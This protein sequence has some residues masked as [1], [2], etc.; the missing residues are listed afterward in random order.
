MIRR[1][2]LIDIL[3]FCSI[4]GSCWGAISAFLMLPSIRVVP[5]GLLIGGVVGVGCSPAVCF[6]LR[7]K[8]LRLAFK[9]VCATV[10][11][12]VCCL[13]LV[14][15]LEGYLVVPLT[16][17]SVLVVSSGVLWAALPDVWEEAGL[18]YHCGYNLTGNVTGICPECG[19]RFGDRY[20][21]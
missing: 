19:E 13:S 11:V 8:S 2:K 5:V 16:S 3:A 20:G 4:A 17:V 6:F 15:S 12:P 10:T 21:E 1:G 7:R 14:F 9:I 18:C